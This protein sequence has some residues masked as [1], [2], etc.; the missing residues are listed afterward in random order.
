MTW[1]ENLAYDDRG[2]IAAIAQDEQTGD[3][4]MLAWMNQEAVQRTIDTGVAHF[5]SRSRCC[6]WRKGETSGNEL[7]VKQVRI[8]C[9]ADALL[10]LVEPLGPACHT[11]ETSCFHRTPGDSGDLTRVDCRIRPPLGVL[12]ELGTVIRARR[13]SPTDDSYT[14]R[15]LVAGVEKIG[16]K[17]GEEA[18]ET[19]LAAAT[20]SGDRLAEEA[21][22]LLYH[23][24]VLLEAR[25]MTLADACAVLEQRR[26][27]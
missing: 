15:L 26:T 12:D 24:L 17:V 21:A 27:G 10:L 22:D 4:L 3:V 5:W 9:D 20:Q 2:L 18:F 23:L 1:M 19:A 16:K 13:N 25:G 14:A 7:Y 6:L 11:G 8:D